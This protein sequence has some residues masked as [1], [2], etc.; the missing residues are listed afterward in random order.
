M[1]LV[2]EG[3]KRPDPQA[4]QLQGGCFFSAVNSKTLSVTQTFPATLK[5]D[6]IKINK[7]KNISYWFPIA[8]VSN[9]LPKQQL[10]TKPSYCF[11]VLPVEVEAQ[12]GP[13]WRLRGS[14]QGVRNLAFL[15]GGSGLSPPGFLSQL[16]ACGLFSPTPCPQS[17]SG[18]PGA[19]SRGGSH[20]PLVSNLSNFRAA[21]FFLSA[22]KAPVIIWGTS[23]MIPLSSICSLNDSCKVPLAL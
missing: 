21:S 8:A 18:D 15:P 17:R 10:K 6:F 12:P 19:P 1:W 14:H 22:F 11:A 7:N 23:R 13:L 5:I 4:H 20:P 3:W 2:L 9:Y 16:T